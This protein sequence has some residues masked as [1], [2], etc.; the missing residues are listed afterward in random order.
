MLSELTFS[1]LVRLKGENSMTGDNC[2]NIWVFGNSLLSALLI[3]QRCHPRLEFYYF[4]LVILVIHP[5]I[6]NSLESRFFSFLLLV[7]TNKYSPF[8]RQLRTNLCATNDNTVRE[9]VVY[10]HQRFGSE[11]LCHFSKDTQL[12]IGLQ[13]QT[14]ANLGQ[15]LCS[16]SSRLFHIL[17]LACCFIKS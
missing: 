7:K 15:A 10:S 9:V 1:K 12:V 11:K 17:P 2:Y 6:S 3:L 13:I 5:R 4:I 14:L 8:C 16:F